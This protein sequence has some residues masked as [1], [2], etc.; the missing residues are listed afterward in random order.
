MSIGLVILV[1]VVLLIAFLAGCYK[2]VGPNEVLIITGGMLT[3]PYVQENKETSTRVKVIKGGGAFVVPVFQKAEVQSLDTFPI[4]ISVEDVMTHDQVP[5]DAKASAVLRVGSDP[6]M[7]AVA[8]EKMLGL[9]VSERDQQMVEV[10]KGAVRET[11][12]E[13]TP[14]EANNRSSFQDAVVKKCQPTFDSLGL[15]ITT[16]KL[17]SLSDKNGYFESLS[18][19]DIA[20]KQS[21]AR[22][23]RSEADRQASLVE[24]ENRKQS[25]E[26]QLK[27][28]SEIA[29]AQR[30]TD[31][32]KAQYNAEVQKEQAVAAKAHEIAS[33]EQDA[34]IEEKKIAVKENELKATTIAQQQADNQTQKLR[35]DADLYTR[36]KQA[37]ADNYAVNQK[38]DA[39]SYAIK[40]TGSAEAEKIAK[41]GKA[42]AD[43]QL[44]SAKALEKNG[45]M[46]LRTKLLEIMPELVAKSAEPYKSIKELTVLNGADGMQDMSTASLKQALLVVKNTTGLDLA[47]L[48][49]K[50]ANGT[51]TMT[52]EVPVKESND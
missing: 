34:I 33:A 31:V 7:I 24:A 6:K 16:L 19:K 38:A 44:A 30:D 43:S 13:L 3:G 42:N 27:A 40:Q 22:K 45:D 15:E 32:V 47:D 26:A 17:T 29:K 14:V 35:A 1:L 10:V 41:I 20:D 25:Q 8:S 2:K 18:A 50:K 46:A 28:D 37:E 51:V 49:T 12:S 11:L 23:A 4:S 48:L 52:G 39:E 36:Q 21:D 9:D 5:V